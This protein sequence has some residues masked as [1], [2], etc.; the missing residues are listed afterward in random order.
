MR[1]EGGGAAT[2]VE[3]EVVELGQP[4][5]TAV[6]QPS[7]A[8]VQSPS[9]AYWRLGPKLGHLPGSD[10]REPTPPWLIHSFPNEFPDPGFLFFLCIY[11]ECAVR[12]Q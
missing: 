3:M 4:A 5:A 6:T 10:H 11:C 8:S 9:S 12:S 1:G 2:H 7:V